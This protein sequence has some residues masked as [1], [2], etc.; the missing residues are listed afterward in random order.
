MET[1]TRR[2]LDL[3]ALILDSGNH[4]PNDQGA[5]CMMEAVAYVA[6]EP[7]TDA[8]VCASPVVGAFCRA[9]NDT[10]EPYGAAIRARLK[11]YIPRLVGSRGTDSQEHMR[12]LL[13]LDWQV[14]VWLPAWLRLTP[15]L[16]SYADDLAAL[17]DLTQADA[18]Y[19][20]IGARV[21]AAGAA[22]WAAAGAAAGAAAWAA[23]WD[24][25]RAAA[26]A[27]AVDAARA[28]AVDAAGGAAVDAAVDAARA[29]AGAAAGGAAWEQLAP[30]I[31]ELQASAWELLDRMLAVTERAESEEALWC[32]CGVTG[33]RA[34]VTTVPRCPACGTGPQTQTTWAYEEAR[35]DE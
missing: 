11:H 31:A 8:P 7:W 26:G 15:A 12:S 27:A 20:A 25:A 16:I 14:R 24:A 21:R 28:A 29:A 1:T 6:G 5:M 4:A 22:A 34:G 10:A 17:P 13:A 23:A 33:F 19:T 32:A 30:T 35:G 2:A 18:D 9:W 3:E